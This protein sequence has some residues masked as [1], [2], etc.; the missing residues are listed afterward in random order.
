MTGDQLPGYAV[1]DDYVLSQRIAVVVRWLLLLT[2]F[3]LINYRPDIDTKLL[4]SLNGTGTALALLNG[5]I[6]WRIKPQS[7]P[8]ALEGAVDPL[9]ITS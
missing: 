7:I 9:M 3:A 5:Y 2:W 6:H 4:W 1:F 8:N